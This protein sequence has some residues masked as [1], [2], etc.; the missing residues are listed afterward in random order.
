M[1]LDGDSRALEDTLQ[2]V[3][4]HHG[5]AVQLLFLPGD[6]P[7][8]QWLWDRVRKRP[9]DYAAR[10]GLTAVDMKKSM[11]DLERLFDGKV[12]QH[13]AAKVCITALADRLERTVPD[14]A[15]DRRPTG[16]RKK[17]DSRV[18]GGVEGADRSL[19]AVVTLG[20]PAREAAPR[21]R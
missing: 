13:D 19:E 5:H 18:A 15:R 11:D 9:D 16:D 6:G 17:G 10:L 4:E 12:Q 14:V 8:E 21:P 7:P 20:R 3:A 2:R 1:V